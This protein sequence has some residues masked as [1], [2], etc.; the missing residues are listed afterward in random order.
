MIN[1]AKHDRGTVLLTTLLI[2]TVMAAITV[3]LM[4]DVRLAVKR[5]INVQAY[6]QA[7]WQAIGA[8]D[9]VTA[10][11]TNDFAQLPPI[12][13]AMMLQSQEPL[14]LPTPDGA[15]TLTLK[16]AS[17]CFNLNAVISAD[18]GEGEISAKREFGELAE[19]LGLAENQATALSNVLVDWQDTDQRQSQG[20]AEDGTYLRKIPP[21]R[22]ADTWMRG[23]E[24][25]RALHGMDEEMWQLFRP[26]VCT[27]GVGMRPKVNV[28]SLSPDRLLIL[29]A[30]L[31][32]E[33][34]G[35]DVLPAAQAALRDRPLDG[36]TTEEQLLQSL[37][38]AGVEGLSEARVGIDVEAVFVEVV[39]QVG[40]AERTRT[41][42]YEG[43]GVDS[44]APVLTYRGWGRETFRPEIKIE[45]ET[46]LDAP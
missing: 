41:Y 44:E 46:E 20:G 21:Y 17:Q 15:I 42:R 18:T 43:L 9:F 37:R 7:D 35:A 29:A 32:G 8:E 1:R 40:P 26:F 34:S 30:A 45:A 14:I 3:A 2:M 6:S 11:L 31:S 13:K 33:K 36:Y 27:G 39:T 10:F 23:P 4:D 25:M 5:T 16:D 28:N 22:T 19:L 12:A 24:E 38:S